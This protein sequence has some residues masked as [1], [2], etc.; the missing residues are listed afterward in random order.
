MATWAKG[1]DFKNSDNTKRIGGIGAYGTDTTTNKL[2]FGLGTEPWD[3]A[4][5]QLTDSSINFKGNK[6][7]HAGDKPTLSEL[8]AAASNHVHNYAGSSS[9][10]GAATNVNVSSDTSSKLYLAGHLGAGSSNSRI[11]SPYMQDG[12][13]TAT[14]F[15][16]SL[17]GNAKTATS[18]ATAR[19]ISLSGDASGSA[20]FDGSANATINTTIRKLCMIG[21]DSVDANGWYKV[22]SQK[23][24]N[25]RNTNITFAVTSTYG[26]YFSGI[27]QLQVR[28]D[29]GT[30]NCHRLIWLSRHGFPTENFIVNVSDMT[31]TLYV[32]QP[33]IQYGRIMFEILSESGISLRDSGVTLYNSLIK[34]TENPIATVV[35]SDGGT[36]ATANKLTTARTIKIGNTAKTFDGSQNVSWSLSEIGALSTYNETLKVTNSISTSDSRNKVDI[37]PIVDDIAMYSIEEKNFKVKTPKEEYATKKDYY[38]FMRDRFNPYS[39]T[40]KVTSQEEDDSMTQKEKLKCAK[41]IG[42]IADEYDLENDKVAQNFIFKAEDGLLHYNTGNYT[43]VIAIALQEAIKKIEILESKIT[44]LELQ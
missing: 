37:T 10:G 27:L 24:Q 39:F 15:N 17:S 26:N 30:M 13:I 21:T 22:A 11:S 35:S 12:T 3:N 31:W 23:L 18:L 8:G 40:Y 16:G 32:Y 4:G 43:T 5:L 33:R 6:I 41:S 19:T 28:S 42:F 25:Y 14:T 38:K 34:E 9:A 2:Y 44:E 20:S 7:Y 1:I 36:V 29:E